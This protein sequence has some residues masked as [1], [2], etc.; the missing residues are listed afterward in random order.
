MARQSR[1]IRVF[2]KDSFSPD[3]FFRTAEKYLKDLNNSPTPVI[4][5]ESSPKFKHD[6]MQVR[7]Y[8][9]DRLLDKLTR[10]KNE[11]AKDL[12]DLVLYGY[13]GKSRGGKNGLVAVP[14]RDTN[15][16]GIVERFD[17]QRYI[18]FCS[19]LR[20]FIGDPNLTPVK[21]VTHRKNGERIVGVFSRED[22]RA[23]LYD[24]R[25]YSK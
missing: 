22:Q 8:L 15:L 18:D 4:L 17:S 11:Y 21:V 7:I 2:N 24:T 9:Y 16:R 19:R 5:A 6:S 10:S 20:I 12:N 14:R 25:K 1:E 3:Y 13:I 23:V